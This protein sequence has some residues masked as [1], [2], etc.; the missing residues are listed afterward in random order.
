MKRK[1]SKYNRIVKKKPTENR[2]LKSNVKNYIN[3]KNSKE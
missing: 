3:N 1:N 2:A